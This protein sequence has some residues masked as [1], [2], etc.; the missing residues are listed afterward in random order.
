MSEGRERELKYLYAATRP[1]QLPEGWSLGAEAAPLALKDTYLDADGALAARGWG[2]RRRESE[3]GER[4]YTLKRD[5]T[6]AGALHSREEI[7]AVAVG[8]AAGPGG[9]TL[10]EQIRSLIDREFGLDVTAHLRPAITLTQQRSSWSLARQGV[11]VADMTIDLVAAGGASWCEL[12][13]EFLSSL[14]DDD[15]QHFSRELHDALQSNPQI[16]I[17]TESKRE[18]ARRLSL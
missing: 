5:A 17:S 18:R 1:P 3:G 10:P 9:A 15:V 11:S 14:S 16:S 4:R 6:A 13:I 7:E 8:T 12:E 2:L